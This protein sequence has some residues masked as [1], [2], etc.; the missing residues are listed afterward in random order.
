ME[1]K[2]KSRGGKRGGVPECKDIVLRA[3]TRWRRAASTALLVRRG[4]EE[5]RW[6]EATKRR[7]VGGGSG[8]G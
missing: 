7:E 5:W 4:R 2:E 6:A 3:R 8:G 1:P